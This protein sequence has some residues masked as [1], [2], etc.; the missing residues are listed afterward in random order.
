MD[1]VFARCFMVG[2][3][4][5]RPPTL[6]LQMVRTTDRSSYEDDM[7][8]VAKSSRPAATAGLLGEHFLQ[9]IQPGRV[10]LFHAPAGYLLT[11]DL[12]AGF[13]KRN[14]CVAWLRIDRHDADP[15]T[16][17]LAL[18][19]AAQRLRTSVGSTTM[20]LMRQRPGPVHGWRMLYDHLAIELATQLP[21]GSALVI[22]HLHVLSD[23]PKTLHLLYT[24]L[25]AATPAV[26][27][28]LTANQSLPLG[29]FPANVARHDRSTLSIDERTGFQLAEQIGAGLQPTVIRQAIALTHGQAAPFTGFCITSAR[30]GT[31]YAQEVLA[32]ARH[33]DD[34]MLRIARAW[35]ATVD[36]DQLVAIALAI[37]L[38]YSHPS[39]VGKIV[40]G[41]SSFQEPWFQPLDNDW[42]YVQAVWQETLPRAFNLKA[43]LR[44]DILTQ[45]C[46]YLLE[47]G[48]TAWAVQHNLVAGKHGSAAEIS[49]TIADQMLD[50]GQ[51]ATLSA[52]LEQLPA[53]V[54][55]AWPRL[56]Y[57]K[58][59]IAAGEGQPASARD[60]FALSTELLTTK[61][62]PAGACL[63]LL[64]ESTLAAWQGDAASAWDAARSAGVLAEQSGMAWYQGWAAWQMGCLMAASDALDD[65]LVY[66]GQALAA[67]VL[68]GDD[69][70]IALL[71]KADALLRS[72]R[73][74]RNQREFHQQLYYAAEQA[75]QEVVERLRQ[76][77]SAPLAALESQNVGYRLSSTPLMVTHETT[78]TLF[79]WPLAPG[80][81]RLEASAIS[82]AQPLA[83]GGVVRGTLLQ[84]L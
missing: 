27:S 14:Q 49:A 31:R 44:G 13:D 77:F 30:L 67:A 29:A 68:S 6:W 65:A 60:L 3:R 35:L 71:H 7:L 63:S 16:L 37:R 36:Y 18:I 69:A 25:D 70:M 73:D 80:T 66:F 57:I 15:A 22:E 72:Q 62:D 83:P 26:T 76:L 51:W 46:Q 53:T 61:N 59:Q 24:L 23:S 82:K 45:A 48:A 84:I 20:N 79:G 33:V 52:W 41:R 5:F 40:H 56:L 42:F 54:L 38:E 12:A 28:V 64:A 17:L 43:H 8:L 47:Q 75:E 74:L 10:N 32:R 55:H 19:A 81:Y 58:G 21:P 2:L 39:L 50:M 11:S 1:Q 4:R 34:L 78:V 9:Q